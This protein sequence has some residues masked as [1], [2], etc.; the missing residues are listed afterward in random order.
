VSEILSADPTKFAA[1][2]GGIGVDSENAER[3]AVFA[4]QPLDA[5][6]NESLVGLYERM[7]AETTQAS[8]VAQ[9]VSEGFRV[10]Q[11]TLEGQHL[12]ISGVSIDDEAVKMISYQR[13]YQASARLIA[14]LSEL[15]NVLVNL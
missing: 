9:A 14:T 3:L 4:N 6:D 1:S 8:S 13:A 15:L 7:V 11:R 10:F 12:G 2:G 5:H